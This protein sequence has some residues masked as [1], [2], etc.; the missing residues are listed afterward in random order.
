MLTVIMVLC[1]VFFDFLLG[2]PRRYH[3]LAGFGGLATKVERRFYPPQGRSAYHFVVAGLLAWLVLVVPLVAVAIWLIQL[4]LFGIVASVAGLYLALG[5][6]SLTEHAQTVKSALEADN[7][8]YARERVQMMV[9][10]DTRELDETGI[11]RATIESVLEN[12]N[13]AV[14]AALFWFAVLGLPGVVLYRLAN[15]LDAMWGYKNER[16]V[17]FGRFAARIDDVLN[18]LPARL[19]A[20]TY[21][22]IGGAWRHFMTWATQARQWKGLN[23]GWVMACG[24]GG[25][26]LKLGGP[27]QYH[28]QQEIRP[29]LG[30]GR[31]PGVEDIGRSIRF[32]QQGLWL[33]LAVLFLGGWLS[34]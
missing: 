28:G 10:R 32:I 4:P 29:W 25:L 18:W 26:G 24:A 19:T 5:G 20:V 27:A 8:R 2:E 14:F 9:S 31:A 15:T 12:G 11:C 33:W 23:A 16:Y 22:L 21:V 13:D 3:P 7:L 1:A 34:A 30:N 6:Q 17:Y